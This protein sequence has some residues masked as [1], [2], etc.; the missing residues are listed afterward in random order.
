VLHGAVAKGEKA[1]VVTSREVFSECCLIY[2]KKFQDMVNEDIDE[3]SA[4]LVH[5]LFI[6]DLYQLVRRSLTSFELSDRL[7]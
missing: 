5:S 2:V 4:T 1:P 7:H 6:V 3:C